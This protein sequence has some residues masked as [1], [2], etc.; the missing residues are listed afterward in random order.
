MEGNKGVN[1]HKL[2]LDNAFLN[3]TLKV[4]TT[5]EKDKLMPLPQYDC[6][7]RWVFGKVSTVK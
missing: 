2:A 7:W 1:I 4:Q 6:I 3:M 5:K